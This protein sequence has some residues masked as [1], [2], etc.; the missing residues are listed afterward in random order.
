[1]RRPLEHPGTAVRPA[2]TGGTPT[3]R[4][5]YLLAHATSQCP[6]SK[7][8]YTV[9]IIMEG[10]VEAVSSA[11]AR[12]GFQLLDTNILQQTPPLVGPWHHAPLKPCSVRAGSCIDYIAQSELLASMI[13]HQTQLDR[14]E[15]PLGSPQWQHPIAALDMPCRCKSSFTSQLPGAFCKAWAQVC[16]SNQLLCI[17]SSLMRQ[18]LLMIAGSWL[19]FYC[20]W[21]VL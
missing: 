14:M 18:S 7:C 19:H 11:L 17:A 5:G 21:A 3:L 6:A 10:Q 20:R 1:M 9:Q 16:S 4:L 2:A 12:L 15:C 8:V 13:F